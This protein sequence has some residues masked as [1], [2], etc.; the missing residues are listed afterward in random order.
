MISWTTRKDYP[1]L[2]GISLPITDQSLDGAHEAQLWEETNENWIVDGNHAAK[3]YQW[4]GER[5]I[6]RSTQRFLPTGGQ[7]R[8]QKSRPQPG[9]MAKPVISSLRQPT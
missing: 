5:F 6:S 2:V 1:L 4:L 7:T 9:K 8:F 3:A